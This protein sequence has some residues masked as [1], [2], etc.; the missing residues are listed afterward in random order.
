MLPDLQDETVND[1]LE[2]LVLPDD[3]RRVLEVRQ[4]VG[5]TSLK[6]LDAML[7]CVGTD[8]RAR[9]LFQ[10]H[11]ATPGRW[12]AQLIQPQNLPRPTVEIDKD[13]IENLVAAVKAVDID[14][15]ARW[16]EPIE[17]LSSALRFALM[18]ADGCQFGV[19]DFSLIET[20][21]LLALAGQHDKCDLIRSGVD[22]Y[23]DMASTIYG[24][25]HDS[26]VAIPKDDLTIE[27]TAQRL[28]GKTTI[29]GCGYQMGVDA[30]RLRYCR[31]MEPEEGKRFAEDTVRIHYRQRG[32]P[33]V[34][35]LWRELEYAARR[36]MLNPGKVIAAS[37]SQSSAA[38]FFGK[39]PR[40]YGVSY[41][42]DQRAGLPCLVCTLPNGKAIHYQN[43]RLA[44]EF[45]RFGKPKWTY[46]AYRLGQWREKEP[47]GGQLT[48]NV[49]Q[50]LAR[51]LLVD[52]MFRFEERGFP[53]VM[54][55]HDE[56]VVES[57]DITK[58]LMESIMAE[59]P[60]WAVKLGVPISVEAWTGRRYRK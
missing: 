47:Y 53:V 30:F 8:G 44:K 38:I 13:E 31:H 29:L 54:H 3:V 26:F 22:I 57:A 36:A 19:G 52:A 32:A 59:R 34:P 46:W 39:E 55:C 4:I 37:E 45:D 15:L 5:P 35:M 18:A 58:E 7:A 23:R 14:A 43:A 60:D 41:Q 28:A 25:D 10:Y 49:V 6:K 21:V 40:Q 56:I 42:L 27:Q 9:G 33:K 16:G 1:A 17:V 24:L 12:S 2:D 51:E 50:A 48:E 20:C 11:A